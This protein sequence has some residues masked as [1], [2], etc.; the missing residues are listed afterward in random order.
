MRMG[1]DVKL[2]GFALEEGAPLP[3]DVLRKDVIEA[4]RNGAEQAPP[5][6]RVYLVDGI[7]FA[8]STSAIAT[9][10]TTGE[11]DIGGW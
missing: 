4:R 5:L 2:A 8:A 7:R 3:P 9:A 6:Q 1:M 11:I 10:N